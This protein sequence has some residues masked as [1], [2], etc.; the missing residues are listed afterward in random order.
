MVYCFSLYIYLVYIG[1]NNH[2]SYLYNMIQQ[3]TIKNFKS[4]KELHFP[5][6]KLNVIIGEPNS[7]KSNILE[8]LALQSQGAIEQEL[9]KEMFRYKTMS[10][11]F[12][13][14]NINEPVEVDTGDK[15]STIFYPI[16]PNGIPEDKFVFKLDKNDEGSNSCKLNHTGTV[17]E[18]S[19]IAHTN[20]H[21]YEFKRLA[22]FSNSF[23]PHLAVP[24]GENLPSLLLANAEYKQWVSE[25]LQEK[26]LRLTLKPADFDIAVSK[27]VDDAIY[28]YPYFTISET[29]QRVIFYIMAIKSNKEAV[30]ILD[31]PESNTFP[32][33]TKYMA[34]SIALDETN[35]FFIT[36]HN[37]YLLLN[38]IEKSK[39][40]DIN[41]YIAE[42]KD[43]QTKL[44]VLNEEQ[45]TKVL[46]F[47]SDVFFNFN[48][49][50]EA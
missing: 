41:V 34:E 4:I 40:A 15:F 37:P 47:N 30:L 32:F 11:L 23:T 9:S 33:Y 50:I 3:L 14:F 44:H 18:S 43:Y 12:Y 36:T 10:D 19:N 26:G 22:K 31:E 5:C 45:I 48:Q 13:D 42:M 20:V 46:D 49:I 1:E 35:Q 16:R 21:F 38:L 17:V 27:I 39:T 8:A 28:S 2:N 24:Y 29:L 7:G 6:K 25:F